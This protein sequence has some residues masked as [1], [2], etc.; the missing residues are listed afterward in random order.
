MTERDGDLI[1]IDILSGTS[2]HLVTGPPNVSLDDFNFI[3]PG[4]VGDLRSPFD[5]HL[6][7]DGSRTTPLGNGLFQIP[8]DVE[9]GTTAG[10]QIESDSPFGEVATSTV[11]LR[12]PKFPNY[13]ARHYFKP[14]QIV[15]FWGYGLG[16]VTPYVP[17]G[18]T[19]P[20][21][22]LSNLANPLRCVARPTGIDPGRPAEVLFAGLA[23]GMAGVY[24]VNIR[25]PEAIPDFGSVECDSDTPYSFVL[26]F[27]S[28]A[29]EQ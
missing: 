22:P 20:M 21:S 11:Q 13:A 28:R 26:A 8:W 18:Q 14:G 23:P 10:L 6:L 16:R 19:S 4:S 25:L 5:G 3:A 27:Y 24:Q 1:E 2:G 17:E 9:P 7:I 29:P 12:A 15:S